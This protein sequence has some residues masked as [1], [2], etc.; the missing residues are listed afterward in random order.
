[1]LVVNFENVETLVSETVY[2]NINFFIKVENFIIKIF[3][4]VVN[5]YEKLVFI[6]CR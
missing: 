6:F 3:V 4:L 1:M 2:F 5:F